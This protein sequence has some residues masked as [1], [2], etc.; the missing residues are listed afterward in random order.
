MSRS[1]T[2]SRSISQGPKSVAD[3]QQNGAEISAYGATA[4]F[5]GQGMIT[6]I[7]LGATLVGIVI[8][9]LDRVDVL[10][11]QHAQATEQQAAAVR[12]LTDQHHEITENLELMAYI[13]TLDQKRRDQLNL[14]E[15]AALRRLRQSKETR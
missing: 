11:A 7:L 2:V 5:W 8:L 12:V 6:N 9:L 1:Q 15:P 10:D 14:Q 3:P 4:K 13:L